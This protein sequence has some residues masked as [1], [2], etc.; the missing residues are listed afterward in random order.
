MISQ[1]GR[2]EIAAMPQMPVPISS[3]LGF[4]VLPDLAIDQLGI[5]VTHTP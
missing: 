5:T 1:G 3:S 2:L 4:A